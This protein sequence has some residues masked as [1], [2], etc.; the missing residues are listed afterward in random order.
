MFSDISITNVPSACASRL[1]IGQSDVVPRYLHPER[2]P[3]ANDRESLYRPLVKGGG[4]GR[5][6]HNRGKRR[7]EDIEKND[8]EFFEQFLEGTFEGA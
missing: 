6:G 5:A 3:R 7:A 4:K 8:L 1:E 2:L